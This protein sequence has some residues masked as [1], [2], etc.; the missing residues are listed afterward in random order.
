[1]IR[2]IYFA[3]CFGLAF[4]G[5]VIAIHIDGAIGLSMFALFIIKFFL[6][7]PDIKEVKWKVININ[8]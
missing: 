6:M 8:Q 3:L 7:L 4:L 1:M 2:S 5:L